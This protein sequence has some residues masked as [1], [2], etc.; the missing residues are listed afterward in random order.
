MA[1]DFRT[2][3]PGSVLTK[4]DRASMAHGLEARPPF[5]DEDVVALARRVPTRDKVRGAVGKWILR[6]ASRSA[7]PPSILDRG[8]HGFSV[9]LAAWLRGP[10]APRVQAVLRDSPCWSVLEQRAF[11]RFADQ[12]A[13]RRGDHQKALW[14]LLVLDSWMRTHA[15]A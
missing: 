1:L 2:Y 12:H 4:V 3:M 8:K 15:I 14:A 7:L 6:E 9:P 13:A 11:Q 10:L 5:L